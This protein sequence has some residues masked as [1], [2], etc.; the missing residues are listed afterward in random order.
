M[1]ARFNQ[2]FIYGESQDCTAF[3]KDYQNCEKLEENR[4]DLQS[5]AAI[6]NNESKRRNERMSN[7]Y[8]NTT[9]AKRKSAPKPEDWSPPLPDHIKSQYK[10]SYLE[11]KSN[12]YKNIGPLPDAERTFCTIM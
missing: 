3:Q 1:K 6:I 10:N 12:E 2:Y 5:A 8:A 4:N 7:H 9:W 11:I